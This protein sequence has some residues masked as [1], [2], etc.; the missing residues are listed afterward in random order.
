[1]FCGI[2]ASLQYEGLEF[3]LPHTVAKNRTLAE[4]GNEARTQL[5][6]ARDSAGSA[7]TTTPTESATP[8]EGAAELPTQEQVVKKTER[9]T[10]KIQELLRNAQDGK[11][12]G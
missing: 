11:H 7:G 12:K 4:R 2:I 1:M 6:R 3:L 5:E 9:I 10:K 8:L